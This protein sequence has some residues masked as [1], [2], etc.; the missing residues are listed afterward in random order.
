MLRVLLAVL[1][2]VL[3]LVASNNTTIC[4]VALAVPLEMLAMFLML[5]QK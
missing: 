1:T 5:L 2:C 3:G 4:D